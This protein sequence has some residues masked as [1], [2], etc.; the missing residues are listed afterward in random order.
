ML[1]QMVWPA[2]RPVRLALLRAL[3]DAVRVEEVIIAG[4]FGLAERANGMAFRAR[5]YNYA[6]T[7]CKTCPLALNAVLCFLMSPPRFRGQMHIAEGAWPFRLFMAVRPGRRTD[8]R[9]H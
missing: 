4:I 3:G 5:R 2:E 6:G 7:S 8:W 9:S 1:S